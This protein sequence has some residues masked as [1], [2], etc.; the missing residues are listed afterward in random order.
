MGGQPVLGAPSTW[1]A[2]LLLACAPARARAEAR[3][4]ATPTV[5]TAP[6]FLPDYHDT[7]W[8]V[9]RG[10]ILSRVRA[11]LSSLYEAQTPAG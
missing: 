3:P 11:P 7:A 2:L 6:I 10:S 5:S 4:P 1:L 9:V 8:S